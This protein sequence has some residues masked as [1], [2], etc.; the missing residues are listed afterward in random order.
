MKY[1]KEKLLIIHQYHKIQTSQNNYR[2]I[3]KKKK[4][5]RKERCQDRYQ[6]DDSQQE[7]CKETFVTNASENHT[8]KTHV[9][10]VYTLI[11]SHTLWS[12]MLQLYLY[13]NRVCNYLEK[14]KYLASDSKRIKITYPIWHL[15]L[16]TSNSR[17]RPLCSCIY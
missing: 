14:W 2:V 5:K 15:I 9:A 12:H 11:Y 1:H 13:T 7:W 4:E 8:P 3:W 6:K 17:K 16:D 10:G